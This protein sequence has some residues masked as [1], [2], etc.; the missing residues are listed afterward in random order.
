VG[1]EST[2]MS[3]IKSIFAVLALTLIVGIA[4]LAHAATTLKVLIAGAS[5]QWQTL[6]LAAYND[7]TSLVTGGGATAHYTSSVNFNLVDS[8]GATTTDTGQIWIVWDASNNVWAFISVDSVTGSRC[9][10]AVPKCTVSYPGTTLP[11]P[12][13]AI[14]VWVDGSTD[15][16]PPSN[17]ASLFAD[18][19]QTV[20]VAATDIRP[21]DAVFA[22]CRVNSPLGAGAAGAGNSD[23]LDGLGYSQSAATQA[24]GACFTYSTDAQG[25][26]NGIG[27][28]IVSGYPS[29]TKKANVLS[30]AISGKDPITGST[31]GAYTVYPIGAAPVVFLTN[32]QNNLANLANVSEQQL[33]QVLSG[34]NCDGGAF[35]SAYAG[36]II[37]RD[38]QS[39]TYNTVEATVARYPTVYP[40]PVVGLSQ[41]TNVNASSHGYELNAS[42]PCAAG[43]GFR[44]RTIGT[45][46]EIKAVYNSNSSS[47]FG[48]NARDGIGYAY[49]SYGNVNTTGQILSD[50]ANFGYV[51]LNNI[52]PIWAAYGIGNAIDP[53]EPAGAGQLPSEADLPSGCNN[54][55]PCPENQIWGGGASYP[56][57][58]NGTYR[59][60]SLLR[61]IATGTAGVN[62]SALITNAQKQAVVVTPDFV[63][64]AKVSVTAAQNPLGYAITD[65]GL[66]LLRSHYQQYD[67]NG[68]NIGSA[69][70]NEPTTSEKGGDMG[71]LVVPTAIGVSGLTSPAADTENETQIV[72][73]SNSTTGGLGPARRTVVP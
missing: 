42:T 72:Q 54:Q 37:L 35:G 57:L 31:V 46:E 32:R 9:Y 68:T 59:S 10:F 33:Q 49:F 48:G 19:S 56:N 20:N 22:E 55:F 12:A 36:A 64:V 44:F 11:A 27:H 8:R 50:S 40:N 51:Q 53:G 13:N 63:P 41:E 61:L 1:K 21:E 18:V 66:L 45:S 15:T 67:G 6:A 47:V 5:S 60:W 71:G 24:A 25:A 17:I 39:G 65:N 70:V 29:S 62:A 4:P 23:G 7:G 43:S 38:P 16:Q 3:R 26:I 30:F 34:T 69:A 52:D 58:R 73:S 14:T 2:K 28:Q